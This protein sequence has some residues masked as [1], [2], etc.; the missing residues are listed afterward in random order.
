MAILD[1]LKNFWTKNK[2]PD[3]RP[4]EPKDHPPKLIECWEK[5]GQY[6]QKMQDAS[7][8]RTKCNSDG[9]R[10]KALEFEKEVE[11]YKSLLHDEQVKEKELRE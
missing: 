5:Q 7:E 3:L 4:K 9:D 10:E 6:A 2:K 1:R 11:K 8:A